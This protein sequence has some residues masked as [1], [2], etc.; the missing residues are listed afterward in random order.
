MDDKY[1][2]TFGQ[3]ETL[4]NKIENIY[5][6]QREYPQGEGLEFQELMKLIWLARNRVDLFFD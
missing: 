2:N 6:F 5:L 4:L 3:I 1:S